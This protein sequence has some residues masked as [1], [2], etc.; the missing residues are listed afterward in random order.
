[1]NTIDVIAHGARAIT[2]VFSEETAFIAPFTAPV[3]LQGLHY[4]FFQE[5]C[6]ILGS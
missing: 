1:M 6:F 4:W 5:F 2:I 3:Q